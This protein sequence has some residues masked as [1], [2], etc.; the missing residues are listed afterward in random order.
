MLFRLVMSA[1]APSRHASHRHA[2]PTRRCRQCLREAGIARA[3][4]DEKVAATMLMGVLFADA[5]GR[6]ILRDMFPCP[7]EESLQEYV[8]L[9]LRGLGATPAHPSEPA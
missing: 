3:P 6:D 2:L 1:M 8:R 9:F 5:M 4:F 7:P